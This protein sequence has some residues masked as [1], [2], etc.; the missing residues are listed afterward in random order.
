M[1][2][3]YSIVAARALAFNAFGGLDCLWNARFFE[4]NLLPALARGLSLLACLL[5]CAALAE[6]YGKNAHF[7]SG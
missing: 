5:A 7:S 1:R 6:S 2:P 4:E 3:P